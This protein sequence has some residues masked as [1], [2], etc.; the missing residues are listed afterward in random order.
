MKYVQEALLAEYGR[1]ELKKRDRR[2]G[3]VTG[4]MA[5]T[6]G[7]SKGMP[8]KTRFRSHTGAQSLVKTGESTSAKIGPCFKCNKM[9]HFARQCGQPQHSKKEANN[10]SVEEEDYGIKGAFY[11]TSAMTRSARRKRI[12]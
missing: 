6:M 12:N 10:V 4:A 7:A 3:D 8:R 5:V 2:E 1:I 9:G 11:V